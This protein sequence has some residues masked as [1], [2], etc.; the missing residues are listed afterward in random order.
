MQSLTTTFLAEIKEYPL[1]QIGGPKEEGWGPW[2]QVNGI[3]RATDYLTIIIS[4]VI[5]GLTIG[6]GIWF[7]FQ[8][9][10]G[11]YEWM[12]CAGD[13]AKLQ[14]AHKRITNAFVGLAL[15]VAAYAIIWIVGK[16]LGLEILHPE[17]LIPLIGPKQ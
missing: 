1:G 8:F 3:E 11:A 10:I 12:T 2:A 6:A 17:R 7:I 15:V 4:N 13:Q 16:L 9:I 14:A 5:G